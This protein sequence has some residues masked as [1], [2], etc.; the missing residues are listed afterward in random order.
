MP[1]ISQARV[2]IVATDG[3][4]EWELFG[5]LEILER[6]GYQ[7]FGAVNAPIRLAAQTRLARPPAMPRI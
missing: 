4:E 6:R 1:K 3:F 2:L 7:G 5:P